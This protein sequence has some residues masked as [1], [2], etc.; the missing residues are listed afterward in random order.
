MILISHRGNIDGID[1]EKENSPEY[2]IRALNH[3]YFVEIDLW[4][5]EY[6]LFLGHDNPKY[7]ISEKFLDNPNFFVH[8]KNIEALSFLK[9]A[10]LNCEYF[11]HESDYCTLTSK[12]NIWVY[13]GKKLM[14]GCI[15]VLPEVDFYGDLSECYGICSDLIYKFK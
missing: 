5:T 3:G 2:I 9:N 8:C 6:G 14:P 1:S 10:F 11:W 7:S 15:A 12:N 4:K 13:P